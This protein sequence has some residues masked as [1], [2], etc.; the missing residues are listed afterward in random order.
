MRIPASLGDTVF[1]AGLGPTA[2]PQPGE[3]HF[4]RANPPAPL[5]LQAFQQT[6]IGPVAGLEVTVDPLLQAPFA[7]GFPGRYGAKVK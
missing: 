7:G 1:H 5:L 4:D 6:D 2:T 3:F